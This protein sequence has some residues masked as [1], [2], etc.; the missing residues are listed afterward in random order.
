[1]TAGGTFCSASRAGWVEG[2]QGL[3]EGTQE[4]RYVNCNTPAPNSGMGRSKTALSAPGASR[5]LRRC[6]DGGLRVSRRGFL[7]NNT[8]KLRV[9][10]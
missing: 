8:Q 5:R 9:C 3:L 1:M 10:A 2:N 6:V 4:L 7:L